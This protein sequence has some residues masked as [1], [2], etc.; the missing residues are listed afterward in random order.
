MKGKGLP[1]AV[2]GGAPP[3]SIW[4]VLIPVRE[5]LTEDMARAGLGSKELGMGIEL[6]PG[7]G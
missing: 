6:E 3:R 7:L 4:E 5:A 1:I 2:L